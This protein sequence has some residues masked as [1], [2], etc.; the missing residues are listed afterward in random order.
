MDEI[1]L[2]PEIENK[3][4]PWMSRAIEKFG[5]AGAFSKTR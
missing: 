2:A 3:I 4:K 1:L 5:M